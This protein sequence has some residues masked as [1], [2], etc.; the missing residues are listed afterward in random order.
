M[1]ESPPAYSQAVPEKLRSRGGYRQFHWISTT[2]I[3]RFAVFSHV[4]VD[5]PAFSTVF[6]GVAIGH[7]KTLLF[8]LTDSPRQAFT[9]FEQQSLNHQRSQLLIFTILS[10]VSVLNS[11]EAVATDISRE[12][13]RFFEQKI[14]PLLEENCL[15]CHSHAAGKSEG[16]LRL[17]WENGWSAGGDRGP[18]INPGQ[19]E[20]SLLIQ[21]VSYEEN[22]LQMPPDD[23]LSDDDIALLTEWIARGAPDPRKTDPRVAT[24]KVALTFEPLGSL[25]GTQQWDWWQARTAYI[26]GNKPIWITTMSETGRTGTHNFHDIYQAISHDGGRTW[27]TPTAIPSLRRTTQPDGYDIA[28][29]DLWPT[30]HKQSGKVLVTGKTFNFENGIKENRLR[31]K[32]SYA[33]RDSD[34]GEWGPTQ[35]LQLPEKDHAGFPIIAVNAGC[36]QRVDLANGNVLLPVRYWRNPKKHSYTSIV[37]RCS[38]D[39]ETLT[40]LE[41]GSELTI[42]EGRGLYE[43]SLTVF[44]GEY[45]L[46]LRA[47]H[48]AFVTK[49]KD[50]LNFEPIKEWTFDD[51]E[52]LGSYNT[53]QHW[54]TVGNGLFLVYTRKGANNDHIMRHR[55]PLF[56]AQVNPQSLRVIRATE[57]ILISEN[58]A[59]LGNSGICRIS[60]NESWVTCGEGLLRL[61]K[62]KAETNKILIVKITAE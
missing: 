3:F 10:T 50:G 48:A 42:P 29:G 23:K 20:D 34:G 33:V 30:F 62:R 59:T 43:P 1:L 39:G 25:S 36:T 27:S 16:G 6:G 52:P 32:V 44:N 57:R 11:L 17:D 7:R 35:F 18:A 22:D 61:G 38:F 49:G 5:F 47:N 58:H 9:M 40:Y 14:A 24:T 51:G 56:I 31:E 26:P 15:K 21:A 55:A 54:V 45:F 60:D 46:T 13:R 12:D 19:P 53:Q 28:P 8:Q 37:A 4:R 2:V 41:H